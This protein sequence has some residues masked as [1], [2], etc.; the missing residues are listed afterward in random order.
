M[1]MLNL[2]VR[3]TL[4][5]EWVGSNDWLAPEV[6]DTELGLVRAVNWRALLTP[7]IQGLAAQA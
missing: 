2:E 7:E 5:P 1:E 4:A 3:Q 6:F